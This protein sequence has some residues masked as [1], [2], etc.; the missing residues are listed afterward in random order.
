MMQGYFDS[1]PCAVDPISQVKMFH[2]EEVPVRPKSTGW[3]IEKNPRSLSRSY[4]FDDHARMSDFVSDLLQYESSTGH[5]GKIT[6]EYPVVSVQVRT[7][8]LDDVTE[9][10][11]EYSVMCDQIYDNVLQYGY[12]DEEQF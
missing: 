1:V 3:A 6:C 4:K 9:L 8:D 11:R 5:Y 7:H 10:D 12:D 2:S